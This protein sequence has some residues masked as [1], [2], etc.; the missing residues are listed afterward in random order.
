[1]KFNI[2]GAVIASA[3]LSSPLLFAAC[4]YLMFKPA[5][6]KA[7]QPLTAFEVLGGALTI[8]TC[9]VSEGY[10]DKDQAQRFVKLLMKRYGVSWTRAKK[11]WDNNEEELSDQIWSAMND[12]GRCRAITDYI[13]KGAPRPKNLPG[14]GSEV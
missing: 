10:M 14:I 6:A 3:V 9:S 8:A 12:L 2:K 7:E 4:G 5:P 1:M 11:I 13:Y